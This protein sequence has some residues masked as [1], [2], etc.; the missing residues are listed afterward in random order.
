M[1][2]RTGGGIAKA[3]PKGKGYESIS[4]ERLQNPT[5]SWKAT[6]LYAFLCSL[7]DGWRASREHLK[8]C[9]TDGRTATESAMKELRVKGYLHPLTRRLPNGRFEK[10]VLF[11][12]EPTET[13]TWDDLVE[14]QPG[15]PTL[16][17]PTSE[18]PTPENP[19]L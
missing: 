6:G 18:K 9:K 17:K 13:P 2:K 14:P 4:R 15:F 12:P 8:W 5:L 7:P 10:I 3:R 16:E 1:G 11:Y 19:A